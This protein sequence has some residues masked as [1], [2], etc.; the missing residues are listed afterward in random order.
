MLTPASRVCTRIGMPSTST[1]EYLRSLRRREA[2]PVKVHPFGCVVGVP[3][4]T[5]LD[6]V[7]ASAAA[8]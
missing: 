3:T 2:I 7:F 1:F 6:Q 8:P 4:R 5:D